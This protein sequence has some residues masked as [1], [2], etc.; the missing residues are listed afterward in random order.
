M[1]TTWCLTNGADIFLLSARTCCSVKCCLS[2]PLPWSS[3]TQIN[4]AFAHVWCA[5]GVYCWSSA[6]PDSFQQLLPASYHGGTCEGL[7]LAPDECTIAASFRRPIV[8][9][10]NGMNDIQPEHWLARLQPAP[11]QPS[12][13]AAAV[14]LAAPAAVGAAAAAVNSDQAGGSAAASIGNSLADAVSAGRQ[15][16][17]TS[18]LRLTGHSSM[19]AMTHG[20][21]MPALPDMSSEQLMFASADEGSREPRLWGCS[22]GAGLVQ[23][24]PWQAMSTP[25]LQLVGGRAAAFD[26]MLLGVLSERQLKLYSYTCG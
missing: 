21:F 23:R 25:V 18:T 6:Q 1:A 8:Q 22:S 10:P 5:A 3:C 4:A 2:C 7:A 24:Q 16:L 14:R 9:Q 20:C 19:Q 26:T 17:A 15:A 11:E 12:V 13:T